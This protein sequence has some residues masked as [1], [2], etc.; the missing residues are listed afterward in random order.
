MLLCE[1]DLTPGKGGIASRLHSSRAHEAGDRWTLRSTPY[2]SNAIKYKHKY[3][4]RVQYA[5]DAPAVQSLGTSMH[6]RLAHWPHETSFLDPAWEREKGWGPKEDIQ[7]RV[8]CL[9]RFKS[10]DLFQ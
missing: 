2:K 1:E 4:Y 8:L 7:A 5:L 10:V 6:L 3:N 9:L